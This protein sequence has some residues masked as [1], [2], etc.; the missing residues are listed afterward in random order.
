VPTIGYIPLPE[1]LLAA[2]TNGC[3]DK[4]SPTLMH[5]QIEVF[6]KVIHKMDTMSA[7][8]LRAG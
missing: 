6:A 7:A 3:I 4:L 8:Q 2:P 1:Y 5:S